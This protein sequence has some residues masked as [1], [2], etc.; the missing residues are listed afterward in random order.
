M[1]TN[2]TNT[3][4]TTTAHGREVCEDILSRLSDDDRRALEAWRRLEDQ[5]SRFLGGRGRTREQFDEAARA[6]MA[7]SPAAQR[8]HNSVRCLIVNELVEAIQ[9]VGVPED[10]GRDIEAVEALL[11]PDYPAYSVL[12]AYALVG[13]YKEAMDLIGD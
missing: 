8:A 9:D 3:T 1:Q 6:W 12:P 11:G 4:N 13:A 2:T 10:T 7:L 5:D